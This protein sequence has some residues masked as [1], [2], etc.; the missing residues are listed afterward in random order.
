MRDDRGVDA[1]GQVQILVNQCIRESCPWRRD[2]S[3]ICVNRLSDAVDGCAR[4]F[5]DGAGEPPWEKVSVETLFEVQE[6]LILHDPNG[7]WARL[8][9]NTAPTGCPS[10]CGGSA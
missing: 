9:E 4:Q 3:V 8:R 2:G 7:L 6:N 1:C 5:L 10:G